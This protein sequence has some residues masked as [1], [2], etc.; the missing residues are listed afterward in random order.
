MRLITIGNCCMRCD[1]KGAGPLT[2][3]T[4]ARAGWHSVERQTRM[5]L[6]DA[7]IHRYKRKSNLQDQGRIG[8]NQARKA[9]AD[10]SKS[11]H[12]S[13]GTLEVK[14]LQ[15]LSFAV[16]TSGCTSA[17]PVF[18][19]EVLNGRCWLGLMRLKAPSR[20]CR[21]HN[22]T[23]CRKICRDRVQRCGLKM[24]L[25]LNVPIAIGHVPAKNIVWSAK[26]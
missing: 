22:T 14:D 11:A 10:M 23:T 6:S 17:R 4:E 16:V 26:L 21:L 5:S 9:A 13:S 25:I 18:S 8:W 1:V 15:G 19:V 3:A 2:K 24:E 12:D 20:K 7:D